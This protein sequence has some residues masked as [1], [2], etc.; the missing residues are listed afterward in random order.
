[1]KTYV[2]V[3]QDENW[4][5]DGGDHDP[6]VVQISDPEIAAR[7][8]QQPTIPN[9]IDPAD[10]DDMSRP[11]ADLTLAL[12]KGKLTEITYPLQIDGVLNFWTSL[13]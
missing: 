10:P 7:L 5:D 12:E 9:W 6:F 1:M 2:V 8:E 4:Q 3:M 11:N 13:D